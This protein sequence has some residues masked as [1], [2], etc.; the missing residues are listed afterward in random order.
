[1]CEV[2]KSW[3]E[4]ASSLNSFKKKKFW[5]AFIYNAN[6]PNSDYLESLLYPVMKGCNYTT[7]QSEVTAAVCV[8]SGSVEEFL[9]LPWRNIG[10][11]FASL[12]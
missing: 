1:M 5:S 12:A 8:K 6:Q 10:I 7:N 4:F 11:S 3:L 9:P 2:L